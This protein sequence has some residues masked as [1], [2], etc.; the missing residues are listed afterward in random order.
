[1][2]ESAIDSYIF[3][4]GKKKYRSYY[5]NTT[6][7]LKNQFMLHLYARKRLSEYLPDHG[8]VQSFNI[9][10]KSLPMYQMFEENGIDVFHYFGHFD[11]YG[12]NMND[13][14]PSEMK[15]LR[16]TSLRQDD[17]PTKSTC[18]LL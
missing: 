11:E 5:F 10:F 13:E 3:S 4:N 12:L 8:L 18:I 6:I 14:K 16:V 17:V 9:K 7:S 15:L 1:M 2:P